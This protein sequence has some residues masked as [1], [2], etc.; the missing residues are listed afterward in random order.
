[1]ND[2][3]VLHE[4]LLGDLHRIVPHSEY[5]QPQ[6]TALSPS[7]HAP[8]TAGHHR[9][10]SLDVVPKAHSDEDWLHSIPGIMAEP[11]VAANVAKAFANK[12]LF[13]QR[14]QSHN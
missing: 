2:I 14:S 7:I 3:V 12:V 11:E 6:S 13:R 4:E 10:R 5:T 8:K 1:L 9:W